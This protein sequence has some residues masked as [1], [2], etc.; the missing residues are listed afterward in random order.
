MRNLTWFCVALLVAA[1]L[2]AGIRVERAMAASGVEAKL[3]AQRV[4]TTR[5]VM[6]ELAPSSRAQIEGLRA[7]REELAERAGAARAG[8]LDRAFSSPPPALDGL[9]AGN[10]SPLLE[11]DAP[12][13][14]RL[15]ELADD[16]PALERGFAALLSAL[17]QADMPRIEDLTFRGDGELVALPDTRGLQRLE[18]ELVLLDQL[19]R[20][21]AV[22]EALTPGR[23]D[24][25][26]V[27]EHASFR[28]LEPSL[29]ETLP[30]DTSSP[31]VRLWVHVAM[32]VG[33]ARR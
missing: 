27:V 20:L 26:L 18:F 7:Q 28:R 8:L 9:L 13:G 21:L 24:P 29:W 16:D 11:A 12:F 1:L 3:L 15:R 22:F 4:E 6:R 25:L 2:W 14:E 10:P 30:P 19:P 23:G 5:R 31:P 17:E 33:E 32:I